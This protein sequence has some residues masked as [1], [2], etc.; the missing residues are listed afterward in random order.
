MR[1]AAGTR[2]RHGVNLPLPL[3]GAPP[4]SVAARHAGAFTRVQA[5][6]PASLGDRSS[7]GSL[8]E[9]GCA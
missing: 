9:R 1:V 4:P 2:E 8:P 7:G 5:L 6:A 3:A